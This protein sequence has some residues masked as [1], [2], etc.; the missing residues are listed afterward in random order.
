MS[1]SK[2]LVCPVAYNEHVKLRSVIERFLN[3]PAC[4]DVDYLIL[5]DGSTDSTTDVIAEYRNRGVG[6]IK[7]PQRRG[8]GAAIR[9]AIRYALENG[10]E[11]LVV[12][13]GNDKDNPDEIPKVLQPLVE[14]NYDFVQGSRYL[15]GSGAGGD[16]PV[17]RRV[18]TRLHPFLM[19]LITARRVT[20]STNG[21]RA[22]RV[23]LVNHP[24]VNIHQAWLDQ[25]ELEPYLLYKAL[26]LGFKFKEVSVTKIYPS[27]KLGYT[28]MKP[29]IGWWSILRPL[30]YLRLGI[31]K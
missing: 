31:R 7:H 28:K 25:Y 1:R 13:A 21:F 2:V 4:K 24:E 29:L 10:Y 19:S 26:T 3:S 9:S 12:M 16:M 23:S 15:N 27:R 22:F 14:E 5:D 8:V 17:Y 20:D 6:T 30:L 11:I 18:A